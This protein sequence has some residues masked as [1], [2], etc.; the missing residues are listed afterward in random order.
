MLFVRKEWQN[1]GR[2]P[3]IKT[4][5]QNEVVGNTQ[6]SPV[7]RNGEGA[8]WS[9]HIFWLESPTIFWWRE[10][11]DAGEGPIGVFFNEV[12]KALLP[13]NFSPQSSSPSKSPG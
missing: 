13:P 1:L 3:Q 6:A 10:G 12:G 4:L 11:G 5:T 8:S 2:R 7:Q 9:Q